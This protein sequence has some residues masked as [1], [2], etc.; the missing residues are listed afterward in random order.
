MHTMYVK[1]IL[2]ANVGTTIP[3]VS[4]LMIYYYLLIYYT[5]SSI[6][7]LNSTCVRIRSEGSY[8]SELNSFGLNNVFLL[9][10]WI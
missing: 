4:I 3:C 9:N 10:I 2:T 5:Y 1:Q 7:N 6:L 8:R